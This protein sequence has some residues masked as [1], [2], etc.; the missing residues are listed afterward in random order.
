M[1]G[2]EVFSLCAVI[3]FFFLSL[4]VYR[5]IQF[6]IEDTGRR[7][8]N[9]DIAGYREQIHLTN[10]ELERYNTLTDEA[11]RKMRRMNLQVV[12]DEE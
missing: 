4:S 6:A 2:Y 8:A 7:R 10:Q 5:I 3:A 11:D 1:S 9:E 12:K